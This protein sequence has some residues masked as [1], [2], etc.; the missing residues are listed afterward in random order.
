MRA[1]HDTE[2]QR[3]LLNQ[4][5]TKLTKKAKLENQLSAA[6]DA[7][8]TAHRDRGAKGHHAIKTLRLPTLPI[9]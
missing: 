8:T 3:R 5:M 7:Q 1:V 2:L 4:M 9:P 6:V